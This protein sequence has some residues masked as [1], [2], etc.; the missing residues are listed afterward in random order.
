MPK[1]K[2]E[3]TANPPDFSVENLKRIIKYKNNTAPKVLKISWK[4]LKH[5]LDKALNYLS[6]LYIHVYMHNTLPEA[7][8]EGFTV[9]FEKQADDAIGLDH[10][11]HITL[12]SVEYKLF[13][14]V[15]ND[16]LIK[17]LVDNK[18]MLIAQNSFFPYRGSASIH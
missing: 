3:Y 14:H 7:W 13:S 6:S 9:L 12:L 8:Q 18:L 4:C 11:R 10:F 1:I 17:T 15:L 5:V 16:T 2:N